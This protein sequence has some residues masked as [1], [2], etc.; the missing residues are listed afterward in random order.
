MGRVIAYFTSGE[1]VW[2]RVGWYCIDF[3]SACLSEAGV[4]GGGF[5]VFGVDETVG[6]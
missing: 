2:C 4:G 3:G 5:R 1:R 6:R